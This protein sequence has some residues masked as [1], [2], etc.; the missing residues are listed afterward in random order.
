MKSVGMN[1]CRFP[2]PVRPDFMTYRSPTWQDYQ[3]DVSGAE[4]FGQ[5]Q[6]RGSVNGREV[7]ILKLNHPVIVDG[8]EYFDVKLAEPKEGKVYNHG[9]QGLQFIL[10]L[11]QGDQTREA[12][13]KEFIEQYP[14]ANKYMDLSGL[15]D[16]RA[17]PEAV[18]K[19]NGPQNQPYEVGFHVI[20]LLKMI[21]D[22]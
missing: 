19:F 10:G 1:P 5:Q 22:P 8:I 7:R 13:V 16:G 14:Q 20:P 6:V 9:W 18:L 3:E 4:H 12:R 11:T 15:T 21:C 17:N 2:L